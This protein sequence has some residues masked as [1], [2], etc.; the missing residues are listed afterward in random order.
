MHS[1]FFFFLFL[2]CALDLARRKGA[3]FPRFLTFFPLF[4][5]LFIWLLDQHFHYLKLKKQAF[6][7]RF[8]VFDLH[9]CLYLHLH[10]HFF[11]FSF[12]FHFVSVLSEA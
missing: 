2:L 10:V 9:F 11:S 5:S 4:P 7:L 1:F 3:K 12:S 6:F 8:F